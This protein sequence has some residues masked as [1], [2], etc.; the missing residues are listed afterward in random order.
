[1]QHSY[2]VM[3]IAVLGFV[4]GALT[5]VLI[6]G[7]WIA[8]EVFAGRLAILRSAPGRLAV[9]RSAP[10]RPVPVDEFNETFLE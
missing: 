8:R 4:L 3:L 6:G 10:E 1:M 7:L 5:A 9:L 2:V